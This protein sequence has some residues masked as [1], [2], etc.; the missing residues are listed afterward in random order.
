[1][2][3]GSLDEDQLRLGSL[4]ED[5]LRLGSLDEDQLLTQSP[6]HQLLKEFGENENNGDPMCNL[7]D[8]QEDS[9]DCLSNCSMDQ[10]VNTIQNKK[11]VLIAEMFT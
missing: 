6:S 5:Q 1:L 4:D 10:Y 2:R 3:L 11:K 8:D 9:D 7:K